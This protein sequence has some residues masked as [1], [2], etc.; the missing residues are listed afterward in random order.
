MSVLV[1]N[2]AAID[3]HEKPKCHIFEI[4]EQPASLLDSYVIERAVTFDQYGEI[5][6]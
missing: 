3:D 6:I 1:K 2:Y 5:K 4:G